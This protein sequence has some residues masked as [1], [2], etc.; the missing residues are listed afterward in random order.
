MRIL[1]ILSMCLSHSLYGADTN[2]PVVK[3][4]DKHQMNYY[5]AGTKPDA[6]EIRAA[7]SIVLDATGYTFDIPT[8]VRDKPLNSIQLVQSKTNQF[9]LAWRNGITQYDLSKN[10]LR[11]L[12]GSKPFDGFKT[13]ERMIIA[14][15]IVYEPGKFAVVWTSIVEVK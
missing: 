12:P 6:Y 13:G 11:P 5:R 10:T 2:A 7:P 9:E 14:I 8:E 4:D 15:G 1:L 3:V